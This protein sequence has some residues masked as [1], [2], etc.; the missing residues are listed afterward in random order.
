[1]LEPLAKLI[2]GERVPPPPGIRP[3]DVPPH[4]VLRRGRLIPWLGGQFARMGRPAAAVT[5]GRTIVIDPDTVLTPSLLAHELAHVRQWRGD[6]L[7][8]L[9]YSLATLRH[10]YQDNPYEVEARAL[11]SADRPADQ[12][13]EERIG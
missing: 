10:G 8:P 7:F 11:A 3:E 9:R 1:M 6:P 5:L 2:L 12:A 4:I 13:D